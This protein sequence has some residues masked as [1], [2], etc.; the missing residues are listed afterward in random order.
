MIALSESAYR[1]PNSVN[2]HELTQMTE[3]ARLLGFR[4]IDIPVD[5]NE[6]ETPE[7]IFDYVTRFEPP[8]AAIW[9]GYIPTV[10]HYQ[11][12][13]SA[14]LKKGIRLVNSPKEFQTAM[15]FDHFY[16]LLE[17]LTPKS[18]WTD[19]L[20]GL[21]QVTQTIG[22]PMFVK[23]AVK[24]NKEEGWSACVA[25]NWTELE[26]IARDLMGKMGRSRGRIIVRELINLKKIPSSY[27]KFPLGREYRLFLL[28]H[29][30]MAWGFYWEEQNEVPLEETERL[31]IFELAQ[32]ASQRLGVPY[33]SVDIG[34]LETGEWTVIEVGDGQFSGLSQ[35]QA[36][37]LLNTIKSTIEST[38]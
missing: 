3:L 7:A 19:S 5:L 8:V 25:Q 4:V 1:D 18:T 22:F 15:E 21:V 13:Y 24:S 17:G 31:R 9:L 30:I 32:E 20:E 16:P 6:L 37:Q 34:Q 28:N 10:E 23:G 38:K 14:A 33:I 26:S 29:E 35:I 27:E 36:L 12:I 2:G 11:A